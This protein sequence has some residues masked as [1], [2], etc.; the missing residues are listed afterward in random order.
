MTK[1][2]AP[3]AVA[4]QYNGQQAPTVTAKGHGE[5]AEDIIA[6]AREHG[7]LVH[8][9]EQLNA[10]LQRMDLGDQIPPELYLVIAELI[11]FSYVLQGKFPDNWTNIHHKIDFNA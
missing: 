11:A 4:L 8:E 5:L 6:L 3:S 9:D 7:I 2:K 10:L 1:P